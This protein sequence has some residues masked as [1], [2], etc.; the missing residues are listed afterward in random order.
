M[1]CEIPVT[2][3]LK[4]VSHDDPDVSYIRLQDVKPL[5][6]PGYDHFGDLTYYEYGGEGYLVM[7]LEGGGTPGLAVLG[8]NNLDCVGHDLLIGQS[9][10]GWWAMSR[11]TA[12]LLGL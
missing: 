7:P 11:M 10:A 12:R 3:D 5:H 8:S 2:H 6:D 9:A 1:F 4:Y